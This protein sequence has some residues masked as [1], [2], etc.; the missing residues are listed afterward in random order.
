MAWEEFNIMFGGIEAGESPEL[1]A[2]VMAN[3]LIHKLNTLQLLRTHLMELF[4]QKL[5]YRHN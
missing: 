5:R 4:Q 1:Q 2:A 3:D